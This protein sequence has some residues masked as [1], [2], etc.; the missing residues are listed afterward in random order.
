MLKKS[1]LLGG[2]FLLFHI[3]YKAVREGKDA[4]LC[5]LQLN[6]KLDEQI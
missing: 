5:F 4:Q 3:T 6:E 1:K 2:V